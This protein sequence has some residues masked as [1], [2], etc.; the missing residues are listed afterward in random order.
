[1]RMTRSA[2]RVGR[3]QM[4]IGQLGHRVTDLLVDRSGHFA[5]LDVRDGD[6][7]VRRADGRGERLVAIRHG[8]DDIGL[9]VV[10]DR[11]QLEQAEAG[12]LGHGGRVLAF[13]HLKTRA[14]ISKPSSSM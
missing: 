6:V 7:H 13:E 10:E 4:H 11:G 5:A 14:R 1:M 12:G 9:Q 3:H 8:D 2:A